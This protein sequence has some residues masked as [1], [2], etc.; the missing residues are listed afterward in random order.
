MYCNDQPLLILRLACLQKTQQNQLLNT[1]TILSFLTK[2]YNMFKN[3]V[4]SIILCFTV[5]ACGQAT[6]Q[7]YSNMY[8]NGAQSQSGITTRQACLDACTANTQCLAVDMDSNSGATAFCWIHTS[9]SNIA[10]RVPRNGVE[11]AVLRDRCP[12]GNKCSCTDYIILLN[13]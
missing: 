9:A 8:A 10:T 3:L 5:P 1:D 12:G 7:P 6:Y 11:H 4:G 13:L 2:S